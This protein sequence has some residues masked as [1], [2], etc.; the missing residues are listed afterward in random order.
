MRRADFLSGLFLCGLAILICFG[1]WRLE[2]GTPQHPAPGFF[3][4]IAGLA[5]GICSVLIW[6][7]NRKKVE[8]DTK[9]WRENADRKGILLAFCILIFYAVFLEVL[10]F[11]VTNTLFFILIGRL[12]AHQRWR[13]AIGYTIACSFGAQLV[14]KTLFNTPLPAGVFFSLPF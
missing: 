14:F 6:V 12:A 10:G 5:L 9:F 7:A 4:F 11:F 8:E 1:A 3:P 2:L 13:V